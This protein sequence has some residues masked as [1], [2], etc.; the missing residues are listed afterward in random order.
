MK[1]DLAAVG[2]IFQA[3]QAELTMIS[4][5]LRDKGF[6]RFERP[7]LIGGGLAFASYYL[8]Y[9]PPTR[10]MDGLERRLQNARSMA[11]VA[12]S[13][14]DI[15]K[16]LQ[17]VYATLPKTKDKDHFLVEAVV[18][19]LKAEG[20]TSDSIKPP[21]EVPDSNLIFQRLTI[22]A[23][24]RFPDLVAW[25]A[26]VEASRPLLHVYSLEITKSRRLGYCMAQVGIGT[27]VPTADT[28]R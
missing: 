4:T 8:L 22:S 9:L 6:K 24:V 14:K 17:E 18:E 2:K 13:Y 28:T 20:L 5:V 15:R 3:V 10:K 11:E 26:R 23:E 27:I 25:L 19:S 21:D 7:L 16:R 12:D 1:I